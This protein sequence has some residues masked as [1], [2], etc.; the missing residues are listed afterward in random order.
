M[1]F[2]DKKAKKK[3]ILVSLIY[4]TLIFVCVQSLFLRGLSNLKPIYIFNISGDIMGMLAGYVLFICCII[5]V[6]KTG[7]NLKWLL[8]LINVVYFAL[9]TDVV[10][11]LVDGLPNLVAVN[12]LDNVL[13]YCCAPFEAFFFWHYTISYLDYTSKSIKRVNKI[14]KLGLFAA[15]FTR[16]LNLVVPVY[17]RITEDGFYERTPNYSFS[18]IYAYFTI[19]ACLGIV[20]KE[21]KHL[22]TYQVVTFFIYALGPL[23]V[24]VITLPIY[25][26]SIISGVMMLILLLIYCVLN[27]SQGRERAITDRDL[28]IAAA[29]QKGLLP[30]TFPPF[31]DKTEID[32]YASMTPAKEVGGDFYDFFMVDEDHIAMVIADVSGKGVPAALFMMI[33]RT[34][35][36]TQTMNS[37]DL[38]P[39]KIFEKVNNQLCDGNTMGL[40]VTAWLGIIDLKTGTL[41]YSNAG[42]EYPILKK[43][44][45]DFA[46]VKEKHSPPLGA[47]EGLA[48]KGGESVIAPGDTI[49]LYTDGV[50][51]AT[52]A[53]DKLF[54]TE[55]ML[56]A[57]NKN[58]NLPLKELDESLRSSIKSFVKEAPQF[59]D[60]TMLSISYYGRKK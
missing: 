16:L 19:I 35:I 29:L 28:A 17:F 25:G 24:S 53:D 59:D 30:R 34:I 6:Q 23:T 51:E 42:H 27:V 46:L 55:R 8:Y 47:M 31:P 15:L 50:T 48:F 18:M 9:F 40:F 54:G 14:I 21:R 4:I 39:K 52:N 45:G 56:K 22:H 2:I 3:V 60:I 58:P 38:D 33:S 41:S 20:I 7:N 37:P 44:G 26:L 57:L 49:F 36:K 32:I 12:L 1:E 5:D 10:A 13:Y 11:W 43:A